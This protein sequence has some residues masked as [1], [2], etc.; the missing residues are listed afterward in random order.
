MFSFQI[1]DAQTCPWCIFDTTK[2]V[3]QRK[4]QEKQGANVHPKMKAFSASLTSAQKAM[5]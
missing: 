5:A 1:M 4:I 3:P 2:K